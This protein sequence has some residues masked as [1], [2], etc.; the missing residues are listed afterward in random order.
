M[1]VCYKNTSV[2]DLSLSVI[3]SALSRTVRHAAMSESNITTYVKNSF[4]CLNR[5]IASNFSSIPIVFRRFFTWTA[6]GVVDFTFLTHLGRK[7]NVVE[8]GTTSA[9]TLCHRHNQYTHVTDGVR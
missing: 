8:R 6:L 7:A 9:A 4:A 2:P 1:V 3:P 5:P